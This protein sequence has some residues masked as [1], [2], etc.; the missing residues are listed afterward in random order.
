MKALSY[1]LVKHLAKILNQYITLKN[2]YN[3]INSTSLAN[4]LTKLKIHENHKLITF[5]V[6][7]LYINIPIDETFNYHKIKTIDNNDTQTTQQILTLLKVFLSQNYFTFQHKIYQPEQ[8]VSMGSPISS[9]IAEIFLQHF[10]DVH[11]KQLLDAKNILLY[12]QYIDDIQIIYDTR[13]RPH[14]INSYI[15]QIHDNIKRNPT[16]ESNMYINFIDL[17]VTRKQTNL[18]IDT[19]RKPSTT[20]TTVNFLANHPIEHKMAALRSHISGKYSLPLIPGKKQKE[21]EVMQL[22]A[23]NDF[24]QN[25]LQ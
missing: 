8:G 15:N 2:Y 11:I 23:R 4:D 20:D 6:K 18:G 1:K 24:P 9:I 16:Y 17:T 25:L 10:K 19:F 13:T 7:D 22:M 5:D 21:W 12:T 14:A 3:V